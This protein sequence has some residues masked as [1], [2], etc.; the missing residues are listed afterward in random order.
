M[1]ES[2]TMRVIFTGA[3]VQGFDK[4]ELSDYWAPAQLW[5]IS[6]GSDNTYTIQNA[7]SRTYLD[8]RMLPSVAHRFDDLTHETIFTGL[9][10]NA[11]PIVGYAATGTNNQNWVI[12]RAANRTSYVYVKP[13]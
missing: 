4:H 9:A 6:K 2:L 3:K 11:T 7:S 1:R 12:T 5:V 10:S 8:L 13:L